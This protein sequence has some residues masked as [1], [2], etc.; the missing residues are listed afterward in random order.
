ME[1]DLLNVHFMSRG[2]LY[3]SLS[4][5]FVG[6]TVDPVPSEEDKT[7]TQPQPDS[8]EDTLFTE[9]DLST[10]DCSSV[11]LDDLLARIRHICLS[12]RLR[13][14]TLLFA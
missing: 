9:V 13:V 6:Y 7:A 11:S 8:T 5:E 14:S 3:F 4:S 1:Y 12:N 10:V 2:T